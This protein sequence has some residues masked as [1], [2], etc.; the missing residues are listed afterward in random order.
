MLGGARRARGRR[1]GGSFAA[2]RRPTRTSTPRSSAG[3]S[4]GSAPSAASCAP[5]G[6]A[7]TR[8]RPTSGC[9]CAPRRAG[10][11]GW[12]AA[13]QEALLDP[14]GRPRRRTGARVHPPPARAAGVVR[15][16]ARQARACPGAR[17]RPLPRLGPSAP[18][19]RRSAPARWPARRCRWTRARSRPSWA[20]PTPWPT[21]I[22][23]VS[24]R[25]FAAEFLFVCTLVGGAPVPARRGGLPV[26][27][28]RVRLGAARRRLLHRVVDHAAEEE[29]RRRRAGPWQGR[30]A[31]RPPHRSP[32][33]AEGPAVRVQPRPPGGQGAGLRRRRHPR[34]WC[35]PRSPAWSR[36]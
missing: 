12:S 17:R 34:S 32:R 14:G 31:H 25:D 36:R 1:R 7:T 21:P 30:P 19:S 4:S 22:D 35:C 3:S 26:G 8:S 13:L 6:P 27:V 33:D 2:G 24:D 23:A 9:T 20:S 29:P 15:A 16:R 5:A 28:A 18:R 10:W 11:S